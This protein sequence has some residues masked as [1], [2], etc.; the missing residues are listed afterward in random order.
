MRSATRRV[1]GQR[2]RITKRVEI[3]A[4]AARATSAIRSDE[5]S[6]FGDVC[7]AVFERPAVPGVTGVPP[8]ATLAGARSSVERL[9]VSLSDL[10]CSGFDAIAPLP[11][12]RAGLPSGGALSPPPVPP[13]LPAAAMARART[14]AQSLYSRSEAGRWLRA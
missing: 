6:S 5:G 1:S 10:S 3:T 7:T 11:V 2:V 14:S 9:V 13:V 4:N 8:T 12:V